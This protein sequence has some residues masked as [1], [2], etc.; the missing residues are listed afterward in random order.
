MNNIEL[1]GRLSRAISYACDNSEQLVTITLDDATDLFARF[2]WMDVLDEMESDTFK[3][4]VKGKCPVCKH[5]VNAFV[6]YPEDARQYCR[7]CGQAIRF[8][9]VGKENTED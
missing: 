9:L 1:V 8:H 7:H 4:G 2:K 6:R 5:F 3:L